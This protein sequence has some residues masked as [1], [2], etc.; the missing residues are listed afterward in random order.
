MNQAIFTTL[1]IA[2]CLC[3]VGCSQSD[4]VLTESADITVYD[5][6]K[7]EPLDTHQEDALEAQ[8]SGDNDPFDTQE[9]DDL[10]AELVST[11]VFEGDSGEPG[12]SSPELDPPSYPHFD[13]VID[14]HRK[15][16][17]VWAHLI[18]VE[19]DAEGFPTFQEF[20]YGDT[21]D[22]LDFWPA[23]TIKI[24]PATAA[25]A[26]LKEKG[27]S[28]DAKA[29]FYH[30]NEDGWVEDITKTFRDLIY[31]SFNCSSNTAYTLLLRF[32]G[33][34]W[35][36][37]EFFVPSNG[38]NATTLMVGYVNERPF[39]YKRSE[40]QKIVV[41]E[42]DKSWERVHEFS[43]TNYHAQVGCTVSYGAGAANCSSPR[44]M[45]EHMKR[46]MFHE[47]LSEDARFDLRI[48]D[49]NW[50]RYEGSVMNN[51]ETCGNHGWAGVKKVLPEAEFYHKGGTVSAYRLDLQY[52][53]D[54]DSQTHYIAA[55]VTESG[56][57]STLTK[58]S[59]EVGRMVKTPR[60]YVHLDTLKDYVNPVK[61]S[62]L[63]YSETGG[64][65]ELRVKDYDLPLSQPEAWQSLAGTTV[66]VSAGESSH[67][68]TSECLAESGKLHIRGTFKGNETVSES[69]L[70]Y[71]I[72]DT[73]EPCD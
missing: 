43:G 21:A 9:V 52:V 15:D 69:D 59:E 1:F 66:P 49:L 33:V 45:T 58:L 70:H 27:F 68:I 23:S 2:V 56:S 8:D 53:E 10:G 51:K 73:E 13:T 20:S 16:V 30:Q 63:V 61:A 71:V 44:D 29:T 11:D 39:V 7:G 37:Q 19:F 55:I 57:G 36:N 41:E 34:D 64:E 31:E 12:P 40:A 4:A 54:V 47:W 50:M 38:F 35:L 32:A 18:D 48:D 65:L 22:Q 42:G 25:L 62:L 26:I 60:A 67:D 3:A 14:L 28:L 17:P 72:V 46:V 5:S 24:Y 6:L